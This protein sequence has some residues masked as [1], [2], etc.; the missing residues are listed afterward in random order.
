MSYVPVVARLEGVTPIPGADR[1]VSATASGYRLV[2]G[3]DRRDGELGVVFPAEGVLD[4]R[5]INVATFALAD[6]RRAVDAA[7]MMQSLD[8]TAVVP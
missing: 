6:F 1:I 4:L 7:A 8:L 3:A 5:K 2:V